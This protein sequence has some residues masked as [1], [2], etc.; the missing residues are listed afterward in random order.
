MKASTLINSLCR[1]LPV[2]VLLCLTITAFADQ[3]TGEQ[4]AADAAAIGPAPGEVVIQERPE[5]NERIYKI[6]QGS[7]QIEWTV[8]GPGI[9]RQVLQHRSK[10]ELSLDRQLPLLEK[11]L[12]R[13]IKDHSVSW[14]FSTLFWGGLTQGRDGDRTMSTRLALATGKSA[15][16]NAV[17]GKPKDG[18]EN[19]LCLK[20]ANQVPIYYELA[21]LFSRHGFL[22]KVSGMEK[23]FID[24]AENLADYAELKAAGIGAKDR[25]PYDALT[26][27]SLVPRK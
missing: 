23:V 12:V 4:E 13:I 9:N 17:K 6:Q 26:W 14:P 5:Y 27:F 19:D 7:C 3:T 16:W 24:R 2:V 8:H 1:W 22:L 25:L 11:L 20:L 15:D 10:C 18:H 21:G